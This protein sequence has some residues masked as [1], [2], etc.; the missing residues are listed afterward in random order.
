MPLRLLIVNEWLTMRASLLRASN[1][2]HPPQTELLR[3]HTA[4][5]YLQMTSL[6][7]VLFMRCHYVL[8][9][10]QLDAQALRFRIV[11]LAA[12]MQDR[13]KWEALRLQQSLK[14]AE[15]EVSA[16]LFQ[17]LQL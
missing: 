3:A 13:I 14:A 6:T 11:Q 17:Y 12:E 2:V 10:Q 8:L 7:P 4:C 16:R 9:F 5:Q 1:A 15:E